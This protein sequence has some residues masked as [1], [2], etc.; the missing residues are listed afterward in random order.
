VTELRHLFV[1]AASWLRQADE[2]RVARLQK[3]RRFPGIDL[4]SVTLVHVLPLAPSETL[5]DLTAHEVTLNQRCPPLQHHGWSSRFNA[6][7]YMTYTQGRQDD[8]KITSYTQW[9]RTGGVEGFA[10]DFVGERDLL[11]TG[12][13]KVVWLKELKAAVL[14]WVTNALSLLQ[15]PLQVTPPFI[16][17]LSLQGVL[18][19]HAPGGLLGFS[20]H[21][22]DWDELILPPVLVQAGTDDLGRLLQPL[23]DTLAQSAGNR[24]SP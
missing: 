6:D 1:N 24:A 23:F 14:D 15:D 11:R 19:A 22:I 4:T 7:G 12:K 18:D 2:T 20:Q 8:E 9:F 16:V 3:L 21:T 5:L 10:C 13:V 17:L